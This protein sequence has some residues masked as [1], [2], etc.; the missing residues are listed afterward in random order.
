MVKIERTYLKFDARIEEVLSLKDVP[1]EVLAYMTSHERY[2]ALRRCKFSKYDCSI[3]EMYLCEYGRQFHPETRMVDETERTTML[4]KART[5]SERLE[6]REGEID[7]LDDPTSLL[8]VYVSSAILDDAKSHKKDESDEEM[9]YL[10]DKPFKDTKYSTKVGPDLSDNFVGLVNSGSTCY[11]NST[12]QVLF[13]IPLFRKLVYSIDV[14][15]IEES[16]ASTAITIALQSLFFALQK[17]EYSVRTTQLT[18]AFGW[19]QNQLYVQHDVHEMIQKLLE[20]LE[21]ITSG[22]DFDR[23][24]KNNFFGEMLRF[25]NCLDVKHVSPTFTPFLDL[26]LIVKDCATIYDSLTELTKTDKLDGNYAWEHED[27][28]TTKHPAEMG[29]IIS[30]PPPILIIHPTRLSFCMETL[31]AV[32]VENEWSF[33]N[34]LNISRFCRGNPDDADDVS[35]ANAGGPE[36]DANYP[37]FDYV[38]HSVVVHVGSAHAGHYYCYQKMDGEWLRFNDTVVSTVSQATVFEEAFS[39][40]SSYTDYWGTQQVRPASHRATLLTYIRKSD[41]DRVVFSMDDTALP[42]FLVE[43]MAAYEHQ[44]KILEEEKL[45]KERLVNIHVL[46][47]DVGGVY[48]EAISE[49]EHKQMPRVEVDKNAKYEEIEAAIVKALEIPHSSI[50]DLWFYESKGVTYRSSYYAAYSLRTKLPTQYYLEKGT[51]FVQLQPSALA[52]PHRSGNGKREREE[53]EDEDLRVRED[54]KEFEVEEVAQPAAADATNKGAASSIVFPPPPKELFHICFLQSAAHSV[55]FIGS[56]NSV[57]EIEAYLHT[58][59]PMVLAELKAIEDSKKVTSIAETKESTTESTTASQSEADDSSMAPPQPSTDTEGM[60]GSPS[61][62]FG[63]SSLNLYRI[64]STP[65]TTDAELPEVLSNKPPVAAVADKPPKLWNFFIN[66]KKT[67]ETLTQLDKY[68]LYSGE[69]I[70]VA[71]S[72]VTLKDANRANDRVSNALTITVSQLD[73]VEDGEELF[74]VIL[75]PRMTYAEVQQVIFD[76]LTNPDIVPLNPIRVMPDSAEHIGL[77]THDLDSDLPHMHMCTTYKYK[78]SYS[79]ALQDA[80]GILTSRNILIRKVYMSVLPQALPDLEAGNF[81]EF[82]VRINYFFCRF[83]YLPTSYEFLSRHTL[84]DAFFMVFDQL[85]RFMTPELRDEIKQR[86]DIARNA[87][88]EGELIPNNVFRLVKLKYNSNEIENCFM[89]WKANLQ[90]L[91]SYSASNRFSIDLLPPDQ[92]E[93]VLP[94]TAQRHYEALMITAESDEERRRIVYPAQWMDAFHIDRRS[95]RGEVFGY[96]FSVVMRDM[97]HK[98][99]RDLLKDVL[100]QIAIFPDDDLVGDVDATSASATSTAVTPTSGRPPSGSPTSSFPGELSVY[101]DAMKN[102][103]LVFNGVKG[104]KVLER[105]VKFSEI[106]SSVGKLISVMLD[107]P[108]VS[109]R[110]VQKGASRRHRAQESIKINVITEQKK[111]IS[112][113]MTTTASKGSLKEVAE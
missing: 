96:P 38:L 22:T 12:V 78:T 67:L 68:S 4:R 98:T 45:R 15:N 50:K 73:D 7:E 88:D 75:Y 105:D 30:H 86:L 28:T 40:P 33:P 6:E 35:V 8:S 61:Y 18:E 89:D 51:V 85:Q 53:G 2:K 87:L 43:K 52:Q 79:S 101:A 16:E 97:E 58:Q 80:E 19:S 60:M 108:Q 34:E 63:D 56:V 93:G 65:P 100:A 72:Y 57:E 62:T 10:D 26:E 21:V 48:L 46:V 99:G 36:Q 106:Q 81:K 69:I 90:G 107:H 42:G 31:S 25:V 20:G 94:D 55:Q 24:I 44:R 111:P 113:T 64:P 84:Q 39:T 83:V 54:T 110:G 112:A 14:S 1:I 66:R 47:E 5:L 109:R 49:A 59:E 32:T 3:V 91:L 104:V 41:Y 27:G 11:L 76:A 23:Q 82:P 13:H 9:R 103:R 77:R 95:G 17:K 29:S 74:D 71:P 37:S 70:V 92:H 102:W